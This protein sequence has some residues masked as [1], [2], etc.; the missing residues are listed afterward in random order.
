M[1]LVSDELISRLRTINQFSGNQIGQNRLVYSP[2]WVKGQQ[3]LIKWGLAA[4]MAVTVDAYGTVYL[5]VIG[6]QSPNGIVATGSHMDT[7]VHGGKFDGLYGVV[8]GF[9]AIS[10]LVAALG[11]PKKTL[12]LISFSEEEGSRFPATFTGSKHY[13]RV[14]DVHD[15]VDHHGIS[16]DDARQKAVAK[17][18]FPGVNTGLPALPDSFTEL[19]IEQ[20]PRLVN[21]HLQIGLVTSIVGQRRFTV[22][23]NGVANH[24]GT[25][26]MADRHD[27]LLL[28]SS[29]INRLAIIARTIS[30][31][32]TFTVGELHVW[33]NTANVIPGKVTF[34]VDTRHVQKAILDQ[35]ETTLRSEIQKVAVTPFSVSVNRWVNDQPT[36][37][38]A[39]MLRQNDRWARKLGLST[40]IFASGAGHDS[41][42][43]SRVVP[44]TMIFV[45]S[46]KGISHAPEEK[47]TPADLHAGVALLQESLK[48]Q[49]Y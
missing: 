45:P 30:R 8:G 3:Q 10:N 22:T 17:L 37:L 24:A 11:R 1:Q 36:L 41:E 46:I 48:H 28:A 47:S 7:V 34:S 5:D 16:F 39:D 9:Q 43:M 42:I 4:G 40:A 32:L 26:P 38:D 23:I 44:T 33:P 31:Q 25:T 20:G 14:A 12:R 49:A 21:Q 2:T 18:Q 35:F 19:H 13:A 15:I 29:L 27:A 6:S